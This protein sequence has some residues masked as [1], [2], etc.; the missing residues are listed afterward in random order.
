MKQKLIKLI[1]IISTISLLGIVFTQLYWVRNAVV[2]KEEQFDESVVIALKSV[3]NQLMEFHNDSTMKQI[4]DFGPECV[5]EKTDIADIINSKMLDSLMQNELRCF[6]INKDYEYAI[7]NLHN[8]RFEMGTCKNFKNELISS[9][10]KVSLSALYKPGDYWLSV[11]FPSQKSMIL[12]KM[13]FWLI[14]SAIFL[15]T[16]IFTF[17]FIIYSIIR[18]KK[19]SQ[20]KTDFVNNM[21]HEFKTPISTISLA[22]EMLLKKNVYESPD[23]TQRYA[24]VIYDENNRMQS[25]VEHVL[26]IAMLDKGEMKMKPKEVDVHKIIHKVVDN[27]NLLVKK[28]NGVVLKQLYAVSPVIYAD[29]LHITNIIHNLLDNANK[30]TP[31]EPRIIIATKNIGQGIQISIKD[32]GIGISHES[33]KN[34]FKKLYRVPTGNLHNVKGFGLGLYYVKTMIE[35]H[36]GSIRLYSE[37]GKGSKFELYLP[38][39][40]KN[41]MKDEEES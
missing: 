31:E 26:Q 38:V 6:K 4:Q 33:Q 15:L 18:Q 27:F 13:I 29:R 32:N 34:I 2:M 5:I 1:I 25:Q 14:L 21:T 9:Y 40:I 23:K 20:M 35:A 24:K 11:Y 19:L 8:D 37:V 39:E 17:S 3:V 41:R 36:G 28:R 16:V 12:S 10:H 22:S 7:I 30:Y